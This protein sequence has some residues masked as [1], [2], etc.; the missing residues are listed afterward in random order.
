M[1]ERD[2]L[3]AT[4]ALRQAAGATGA[5]PFDGLDALPLG[6]VAG[7]KLSLAARR[8][9]APAPGRPERR[10]RVVLVAVHVRWT[11]PLGLLWTETVVPLQREIAV[12]T[13]VRAVRDAATLFDEDSALLFAPDDLWQA[14][15]LR[16][17][18]ELLSPQ[19]SLRERWRTQAR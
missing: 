17:W 5:V 6:R 2:T 12:T 3:R 7:R 18:T 9:L 14:L 13:D 1:S 11:G 16:H 19:G 15:A 4:L 8:G 10:G